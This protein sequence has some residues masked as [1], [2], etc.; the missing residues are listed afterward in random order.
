MCR[1]ARDFA[2]ATHG[3]QASGTPTALSRRRVSAWRVRSGVNS[4]RTCLFVSSL[5]A[6]YKHPFAA[7][8]VSS[9]G[10]QLSPDS[11]LSLILGYDRCCWCMQSTPVV[12]VDLDF[13]AEVSPEGWFCCDRPASPS[14][15]LR[16]TKLGFT[17]VAP[18]AGNNLEP[19]AGALGLL[20]AQPSHLN[21][22][23]F[24]R[25]RRLLGQVSTTS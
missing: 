1:I 5:E 18:S 9:H 24:A 21:P 17:S 4:A 10:C 14:M 6:G 13:Y 8:L 11:V 22:H 12:L 16:N 3:P 23:A 20:G 19:Q 15:Q 7:Q 2:L 25:H